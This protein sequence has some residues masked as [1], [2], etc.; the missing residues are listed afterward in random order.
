MTT[1]EKTEL[2]QRLMSAEGLAARLSKYTGPFGDGGFSHHV[3]ELRER[4]QATQES[5]AKA[6]HVELTFQGPPVQGEEGIRAGFAA[7]AVDLFQKAVTAFSEGNGS[8]DL[9]ITAP[10]RGSFGF[11]LEE[12]TQSDLYESPLSATV[13]RVSELIGRIAGSRDTAA[14]DDLDPKQVGAL[15]GLMEALGKAGVRTKIHSDKSSAN[16]DSEGALWA[17]TFMDRVQ[18]EESELHLPGFLNG[19]LPTKRRFEFRNA[20]GRVITGQ[21]AP[22]A[23]VEQLQRWVQRS[24]T[25]V[26]AVTVI[27]YPSGKTRTFQRLRSVVVPGDVE[28]L[29]LAEQDEPG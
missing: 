8:S 11:V 27:H 10:A 20:D 15:Q 9:F 6:A 25:A 22:D 7:K 23:D 2:Q 13:D 4:L 24:C 3:A 29:A 5:K 14:V 16:V 17:A 28:T 12:L 18:T 1:R 19:V 26:M 21:L